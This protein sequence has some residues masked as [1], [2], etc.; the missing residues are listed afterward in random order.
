[1]SGDNFETLSS[2]EWGDVPR[3]LRPWGTPTLGASVFPPVTI[4]FLHVVFV[5][6]SYIF[7]QCRDNQSLRAGI[8][9]A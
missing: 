3:L 2:R 5:V 6:D 9:S 8:S 7:V 1:M 4:F